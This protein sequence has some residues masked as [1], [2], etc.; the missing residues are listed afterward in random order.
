M[1][2][3]KLDK[4]LIEHNL[5][6]ISELSAVTEPLSVPCILM[7]SKYMTINRYEIQPLIDKSCQLYRN[8]HDGVFCPISPVIFSSAPICRVLPACRPVVCVVFP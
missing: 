6:R 8:E 7:F 5:H 2:I 3:L 1:R 4:S